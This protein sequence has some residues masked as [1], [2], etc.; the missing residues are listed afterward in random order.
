MATSKVRH[1]SGTVHVA[2]SLPVSDTALRLFRANSDAHKRTE[3]TIMAPGLRMRTLLVMLR[4]AGYTR[5]VRFTTA[6]LEIMRRRPKEHGFDRS[7]PRLRC[8]PATE[9]LRSSL[10]EQLQKL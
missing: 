3:T 8:D 1:G 6:E 10:E 9:S 5:T 7:P 2:R 4:S